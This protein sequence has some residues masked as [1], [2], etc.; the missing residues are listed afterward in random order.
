MGT[1]ELTSPSWLPTLYARA[2]LASW[3]SGGELPDIELLRPRVRVDRDHLAAYARVCGFDLSD[4]LPLTYPH[5]L[6]F[7]MQLEL[8][9][10]GE[11]PYPLLGLVHIA[12]TFTRSRAVDASEE[13]TVRVRATEPG[14]HPKGRTF[15]L[16]TEVSTGD[17][18]VWTGRSTYLYRTGGSS[19]QQR[20]R[21]SDEPAGT[22]GAR[23]RLS[24]DAGRRYAD[25]SDDRNPIH[26][27]PLTSRP[28]GFRRPI[29]HGMYTAARC[30]AALGPRVPAVTTVDVEFGAPLPLPSTVDFHA[31]SGGKFAVHGKGGR[32]H[33]AG[34]VRSA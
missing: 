6:G 11:F 22:P 5:V 7:G 9:T 2:L 18:V 23:W 14:E 21:P 27:H 4:R 12:N 24:D 26:L 28:F 10:S 30:L 19:S 15:V 31:W 32:R 34:T 1:R 33:L 20:E 3:R 16:V 17:E 25:V 29:A 8:M 13:L